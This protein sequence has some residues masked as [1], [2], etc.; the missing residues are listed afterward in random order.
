MEHGDTIVFMHAV[1][2]GPANQ[3]YGLQVAQLAGVPPE[4]IKRARTRLRELE[5]SARRHADQVMSQ[6]SLFDMEPEEPAPPIQQ[7]A[8]LDA[9]KKIKPDE[10]TPKQALDELYRLILLL[11]E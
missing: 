1:K 11:E 2:E 8:A 4:V 5:D 7:Q 9:L 10:M 3:S 6:L